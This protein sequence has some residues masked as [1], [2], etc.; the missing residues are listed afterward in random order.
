MALER[1][2]PVLARFARRTL[3]YG[4]IPTPQGEYWVL[5]AP[6]QE[7]VI[8][9]QRREEAWAGPVRVRLC[10]GLEL[11]V[12]DHGPFRGL[13]LWASGEV[14]TER[15]SQAVASL[16]FTKLLRW[17]DARTI[18]GLRGPVVLVRRERMPKFL[19]DLRTL[20]QLYFPGLPPS[21][22]EK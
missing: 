9:Y 2:S 21:S 3:V 16:S 13:R 15:L 19:R 8:F 17:H 20:L 14:E 18:N 10:R 5:V 11:H 12:E 7:K 6:D 4:R 1:R 22:R